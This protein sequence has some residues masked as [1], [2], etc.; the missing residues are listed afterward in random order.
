M[1]FL[2]PISQPTTGARITGPGW[3]AWA[4]DDRIDLLV[5]PHL[6]SLP[7]A[8]AALITPDDRCNWTCSAWDCGGEN[9]GDWDAYILTRDPGAGNGLVT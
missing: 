9:I 8:V 7:E 2:M 5:S 3:G 1:D 4:Q 6:D